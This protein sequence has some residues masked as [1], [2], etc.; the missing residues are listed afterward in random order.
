MFKNVKISDIGEIVSGGTPK[1]KVE[2]YWNGDIPWITPKDLSN[3]LDMYIEKGERTI[4]QLGLRSSSAR[5]LPKGTVLFTSRTPIGNVA[6]AKNAVTTNQG[7]KSIIVND[8]NNNVFIYYLLQHNK[9]LIESYASGSTFKEISRSMMKEIEVSVPALAEQL[10]IANIL[11]SLDAKIETN[12]E[13]NKRL[14]EIAQA[15]FK[16]WF[17]NFDFPNEDE[18]GKPYKFSGGEMVESELGLIPRGWG[19]GSATEQ[20]SV[21]SGGTPKTKIAE[22]WNGEIPFF[23]PKDSTVTSV[24]VIDTE[25]SI[26]QEGLSNCNSKLYDIGTVFITL[27]GTVGEVA[28]AGKKMAMNHSCY[29]LVPNSGFTYNYIYFLVM[30]LVKMLKVNA[31]GSVFNA[32]IVSTFSNLKTVVPSRDII[33]KFDAIVKSLFSQI[34][35]NVNEN[36]KL[37]EIRDTLLPKLMSGEIRVQVD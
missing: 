28:M 14:E 19:V 17:V 15:I 31:S 26:T 29:A 11:S 18:D 36:K 1:T 21:Q 37:G 3:N 9:R 10:A 4:S 33:E 25:K 32:L 7:F 8:K 5:L 30:E 12:N 34:L 6:I 20:F 24:F 22:Y 23:T 16:Q 13:I 35:N 2:E 27:R